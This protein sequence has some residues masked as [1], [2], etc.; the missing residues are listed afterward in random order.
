V[1]RP[2][3]GDPGKPFTFFRERDSHFFQAVFEAAHKL[4]SW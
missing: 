3:I 2:F 4:L 1:L